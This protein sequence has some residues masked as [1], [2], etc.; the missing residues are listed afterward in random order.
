MAKLNTLPE[1]FFDKVILRRPQLVICCILIVVAFLGYKAKDFRLDASAETLIIENDRD[2]NYSRQIDARYGVQDFLLLSYTP[3]DDLFSDK[4]LADLER[5]QNELLQLERVSSV[6]SILNVPLLKS[7]PVPIKELTDNIQ[8]LQSPTVDRKLARIEFSQSPLYQNLLVSTD[9]K[10]TALQITFP[11]DEI[12][13]DLLARRNGLREKQ[14]TGTLS[15]AETAEFKN[16]SKKLQKHR[17]RMKQNRHQDITAIRG[18]MDKYRQDAELFLGGVSMI[19]DDLVSFIKSDLK[20]FGLGVLFFLII[21]LGII[22]L[23]IRWVILPLLCCAFSA[24]SMMG[25][26]GLFGWEVT[27]ISS[28]FISLQLIIT[29]AITIHLIV[30]YRELH[31]INPETEQR[32]LVLDTLRLMLKPCL[33]AALTTMAGFGSL[34][35]CDILPVIAFGWMMIGGI[36]VSLI[37]TFLLFPAVLML[38][39]KGIPPTGRSQRFAL[40]SFLAEFTEARGGLI[41]AIS[42]IILIVGAI[43]ISRLVVENSFIDYFKDTTEIYQGMKVIDQKLGGTTSMD[44][45]VDLV[46]PET[47]AG[48]V[49][50]ESDGDSNDK[51]NEFD[52]FDKTE[53][54]DK[55]WFT[56]DKMAVVKKVHQYLESLPETGK[57]VSLATLLMIAEDL[58]DGKPLDN[59]KLA[60]LYSEIPEK[61]KKSLSAYVSVEH[62]QVRFLARVRDSD[63]SLQR[64][65]LLQQIRH[66][67]TCKLGIKPEHFKLSGMLILYNNMLQSLFQSQILTIGFVVLA[68][69][70]MVLIL[71]KS[72]KISLIAMAP[73]L[74]SVATV[75]GV[76][77]WIGIPLDIMTITIAAIS[78][79]IAVDDT[80]HY[81]HRFKHEFNVDRNYIN[82]MHRCHGSIG[83]AMYYTSVTIIIGFSI[84]VLSNF[85]PSIYFGLLTGLAMLIALIAAL[86]L[87]PQLIVVFKPFG[88]ENGGDQSI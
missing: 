27:V 38:L 52:E 75:L 50:L 18:I 87:L 26:L 32:K 1:L 35:L 42:G 80:I 85:I 33:Y 22:F 55:Y 79:G 6:V 66:D 88:L 71:F 16:A 69:M 77:G 7:P 14:A 23:K 59:F 10:T 86:T 45:I 83:H 60:L 48:T 21:T 24:I 74:L 19:A 8:T 64:N 44:V 17:D 46:E 31:F 2:L 28:N 9:L 82:T 11:V 41:L 78:L 36:T 67:L 29:M 34:L 12:Y 30:R 81:I 57:V 5:L 76:M 37:L 62:N 58:N 70:G 25:L 49:A 63:K 68:L 20:I 84:L 72:L 39:R 15:A 13:Q 65:K 4:V 47:S 53:D 3:R 61:F 43:G 40:T 54:Q 73:N 51:F 56:S